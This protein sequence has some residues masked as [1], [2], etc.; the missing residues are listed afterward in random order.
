MCVSLLRVVHSIPVVRP[1][2]PV[3]ARG[4]SLIGVPASDPLGVGPHEFGL[5]G[6][7]LLA[8][9]RAGSLDASRV[10][11]EGAA[12]V[13]AAPA[14]PS[15]ALTAELERPIVRAALDLARLAEEVRPPARAG[16]LAARTAASAAAGTPD[17]PHVRVAAGTDRRQPQSRHADGRG[18]DERDAGH[19]GD[20]LPTLQERPAGGVFQPPEHVPIERRRYG[21]VG[22]GF[23]GIPGRP[24]RL[25]DDRVV[26]LEPLDAESIVP[27][28]GVG[29]EPRHRGQDSRDAGR[30]DGDGIGEDDADPAERAG[31]AARQRHRDERPPTAPDRGEPER[32]PDEDEDQHRVEGG[33]QE[34]R[35]LGLPVDLGDGREQLLAGVWP[36]V[37][38]DCLL[39]G[40]THD[41]FWLFS[42]SSILSFFS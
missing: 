25:I 5:L 1:P 41:P 29:D 3:P 40:F 2:T 11:L 16:R 36:A 18:A 19:D 24:E 20:E 34:R 31:D 15:L 39:L 37:G 9:R 12:A 14:G 28:E 8:E 38:I 27:E 33:L 7:L 4:F 17:R 23:G 21:V 35:L 32:Q 42:N 10:G 26:R 30:R 22:V 6:A 13:V